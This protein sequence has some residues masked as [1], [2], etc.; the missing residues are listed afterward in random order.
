MTEVHRAPAEG[1]R[2]DH[3]HP[4]GMQGFSSDGKIGARFLLSLALT[5]LVLVGEVIGGLLTGSLA[6]LSD[7]AHVFLDLFALGLAYGA[8]RLAA[9]A[10][11]DRHTYGF[12]RMK[13]IAAFVNGGSLLVVAVE[14]FREAVS[15]FRHPEPVLAGPMLVVAAVGL[16]ANLL[17]AFVLRRHDH[18]DINTRA[19]FFHVLG[20][21]LSSV[22]VIAAAIVLFLTGWTWIDPLMSV[23][24]GIVILAGS[25][26][27]L[28]QAVHIL[29]EGVPEGV[30]LPELSIAMRSVPAVADVHDLHVWTVGPGYPVLSAHVVLAD[31]ALSGADGIMCELK[32]LLSRRFG[33]DHTTIQFECA[34]CG[35]GARACG[36][37]TGR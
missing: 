32:D 22:G 35:Q 28:R 24:I 21:A 12:H 3:A 31:Q 16:A 25:G 6:L 2:Q 26:R 14:I 36:G 23:L 7:A 9:R 19:A 15:R 27:V 11:S 37:C 33:I 20:D 29:N 34:D 8:I 30:H 18:D 1:V 10:A 5:T 17:V 13:V 4:H